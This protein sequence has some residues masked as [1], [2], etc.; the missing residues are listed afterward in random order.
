MDE[1]YE[2]NLELLTELESKGLIFVTDLAINMLVYVEKLVVRM[3]KK[4]EQERQNT[5]PKVLNI[6][7]CGFSF[8]FY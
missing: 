2:G 5:I 3:P 7:Q 8:Q 4:S 1:S 6:F